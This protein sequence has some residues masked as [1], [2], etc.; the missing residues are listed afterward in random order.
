[1]TEQSL[2]A[3]VS[4]YLSNRLGADVRVGTLRRFPVGFS[5][6]T[7]GVDLVADPG[8]ALPARSMILRMGADDG[9]YAPYSSKRQFQVLAALERSSMPTPRVYWHSDDRRLL[10]APFFFCEHSVGRAPLPSAGAPD[11]PV[12]EHRANLGSQ[13]VAALA[14]LHQF[15]WRAAPELTEWDPGMTIDNTALHQIE[16]GLEDYR[17]WAMQPEPTVLWA[18]SW[19]RRHA[20]KASR[21]A[22]VHGDYR[23]GNFLV[24]D[25][26]ITAMLD[27]EST[28]IGD[29]HEDLG[30][31][32]LAQFNGGS[33]LVSRLLPEA[34][35]FRQYEERTGWQVDVDVVRYYG[36]MSMLKLALVNLAAAQ[37]F[38]LSRTSDIRMAALAT[39][40]TSTLRQ[41]Q[42]LIEA[43]R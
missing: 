3:R 38:Q 11:D 18:A 4:A 12:P 25:G 22:I 34:D 42:K 41:V 40:S 6:A 36:V 7:F 15:D 29:P 39:Q 31:A 32:S 10:G 23:I 5:W 21:L 2:E 24:Q 1:M 9:L 37:R 16:V 30:W 27:W 17:R 33:G 8:V 13:F 43:V 26:R 19:L 20:P 28:H 14:Q 35:F